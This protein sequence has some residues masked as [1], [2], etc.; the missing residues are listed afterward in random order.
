M[1]FREKVAISKKLKYGTRKNPKKNSYMEKIF[2]A[3]T[4]TLNI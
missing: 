3:Y 2:Q 1:T 4:I